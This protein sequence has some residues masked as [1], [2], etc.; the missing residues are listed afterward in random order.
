LI[1]NRFLTIA[2]VL[3]LFII[4]A[5][6]T[7]KQMSGNRGPILELSMC[8]LMIS[9][10]TATVLWP[11]Y[12]SFRFARIQRERRDIVR[13]INRLEDLLAIPQGKSY[14]RFLS[15]FFFLCLYRL[16]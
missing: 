13:R 7:V 11:I 5:P 6:I 8:I 2:Y 9:I 1:W 12:L 16:Q 3:V 14:L 15:I 10:Y 4:V